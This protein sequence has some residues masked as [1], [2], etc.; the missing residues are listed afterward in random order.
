[1]KVHY[2]LHNS[3]SPAP[4]LNQCNSV[5]DSPIHFLS[6]HFNIILSSTSRSSKLFLS[7]MSPQNPICTSPVSH[8]CHM[9]CPS[10]SSWFDQPNSI[11][12]EACI[13]KL[14][15]MLSSLVPCYLCLLRKIYPPQQ[16]K[17]NIKIIYSIILVLLLTNTL[18]IV[19]ILF[20]SCKNW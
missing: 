13:M 8:T 7:I 6:I 5:H 19:Y 2:R 14:L 1:M 4:I 15:V 20:V 11:W 16:T 10:H 18:I 17:L 12:W 3:P 9:S